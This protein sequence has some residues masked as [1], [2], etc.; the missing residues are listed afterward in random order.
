VVN[1]LEFI[2]LLVIVVISISWVVGPLLW[3]NNFS[4]YLLTAM[5]WLWLLIYL[6]NNVKLKGITSKILWFL[7]L[8]LIYWVGLK[9]LLNTF[10]F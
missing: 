2:V 9:L 8:V 1:L 4:L 5:W 7:V 10:A 3:F 6:L